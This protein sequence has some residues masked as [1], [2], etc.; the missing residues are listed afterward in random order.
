MSPD[1]PQGTTAALWMF[2]QHRLTAGI[3][4]EG[5]RLMDVLNDHNLD[6]LQIWPA[7][8]STE[9]GGEPPGL[10]LVRKASVLVVARPDAEHEAPVEQGYRYVPKSAYPVE[11]L[12]GGY[13]IRGLVHLGERPDPLYLLTVDLDEFFAVTDAV[14]E[15][16]DGA[17][18]E[19]RVATINRSR[20]AMLR[21]DRQAASAG[22]AA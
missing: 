2:D 1:L 9:D 8:D 14:I 3:Q 6:L 10:S 13:R 5:Y 18:V 19:A 12:V 16:P 7:G 4:T 22:E 20:V 11:L 17:R 21:V 15:C